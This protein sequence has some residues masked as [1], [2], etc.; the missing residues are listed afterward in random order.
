M[1]YG[2]AAGRLL[3]K[4]LVL[5]WFSR[6]GGWFLDTRLSAA[7]VK[8]F[9]KWNGID[10]SECRKQRF[11]SYNDFFTRELLPEARPID[12]ND[13]AWISPCDARL[14]VWPITETGKFRIKH[15]DYTL[16]QLLRSDKLA[17]RYYGGM[18]WL[19]RLCVDD[20]H[21]YVYPDDAAKSENIRI[22]GVFHTVNP[23]A[24]DRYPIYKENTREYCLMR[25]EHF[26]TVV[27]M[28]V[29]ALLVGRIENR[30][31]AGT[32]RRGQEK[33]HFAFGGSTILLITQPGVVL[34]EQIF[35]SNTANGMETKVRMGER[36][37]TAAY[38]N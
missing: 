23:V 1:L 18:L 20:Y 2:H 28:E 24:N 30:H 32:V 6:V 15:T 38:M 7:A 27:M 13:S 5:P 36:V 10:L 11:T 35:L 14:S 29:G 25:T 21:R 26:G 37:G 16:A 9:V 8:P 22:P 3:L 34:P 19:Y 31:G 4:P 17:K 33:G 12:L